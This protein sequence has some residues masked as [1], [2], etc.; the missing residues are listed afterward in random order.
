M[1]KPYVYLSF[2]R[3]LTLRLYC[4]DVIVVFVPVPCIITTSALFDPPPL[5]APVTCHCSSTV[6]YPPVAAV[7]FVFSPESINGADVV[8]V[9]VQ[10]CETVVDKFVTVLL[11]IQLV[12]LVESLICV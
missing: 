8:K 11:T 7:L 9:I 5:A 12:P 4:G 10:V 1:L 3:T 6:K 2:Y